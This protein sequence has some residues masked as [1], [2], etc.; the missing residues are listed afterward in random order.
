[1]CS[2]IQRWYC[3]GVLCA[4]PPCLYSRAL[5][6]YL[7]RNPCCTCFGR[8]GFS[9]G[10]K[11]RS[12]LFF[13]AFWLS[14][15]SLILMAVGWAAVSYDR[16]TVINT[17]WTIAELKD[18]T[19]DGTLTLYGGLRIVSIDCDGFSCSADSVRYS[20]S[21]ECEFDF[22][23]D[24][25]DVASSTVT[26]AF[27]GMVTLLPQMSTDLQRSKASGDLNCQKTF[28]ILTGFIGLVS[29]LAAL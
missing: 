1:M 21:N 8:I 29:S 16:G 26:T 5:F 12:Q 23:D 10:E 13:I 2:F 20:N 6:N 19:D 14:F 22:C 17:A 28:G 11:Y 9:W 15:T 4:P 27:M 7:D 25:A 24:C 18:S 3:E